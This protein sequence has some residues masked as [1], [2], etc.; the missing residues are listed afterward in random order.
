M[1]VLGQPLTEQLHVE[2]GEPAHLHKGNLALTDHGI[3]SMDG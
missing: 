2:L 3:E 1:G